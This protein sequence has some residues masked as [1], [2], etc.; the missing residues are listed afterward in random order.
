MRHLLGDMVEDKRVLACVYTCKVA[1][2]SKILF[3]PFAL[4]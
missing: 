2:T 3:S 1:S 4:G